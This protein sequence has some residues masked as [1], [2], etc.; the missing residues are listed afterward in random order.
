MERIRPLRAVLPLLALGSLLLAGAAAGQPSRLGPL[1]GPAPG[2]P[3]AIAME[4]LRG[5]RAALGLFPGDLEEVLVRDRYVTGR[6]GVTHLYLRQ[7]LGGIDV[8][9]A[10]TSVGVDRSGRIVALGL[11]F[12]PDLRR[13]V[14]PRR[15]VLSAAEAVEAA[16]AS[17]GLAATALLELREREVGP[18]RAQLFEPGGLSRDPIPVRLEYVA[19]GSSLRL[20]WNV[21]IRTP[22]GRHWWNLHVDAESGELLRGDDWID[23]DSYQVFPLPLASPDEGPRSLVVDAADPLASPFGWH[24]TNGAPGAEFSD[25]RGNNVSAQEDAD[26]NDTGGYRPDGGPAR[27]FDFPL[28]QGLQPSNNRDAA[29]AQLFHLTSVIHDVMYHYGFDEAA[30]NFQLNNYGRGGLAGDPVQADAQDGADLDNARF[31]TPPDGGDGRMEMFLWEQDPA[32]HVEV[33]S[34]P[35]VAGSYPAGKALFGAGTSGLGGA[36]VRALDPANASGPSTSDACSPL[37]NPGAVAGNIALIDR[38]TCL[39]VEKVAR[40]QDAGAS[41]VIVVNNQGNA[42]V[43][44]A[45]V[46][47]SLLIPALFLGQATGNAIAAALGSGV[48]ATLVSPADRDSAFDSGVVVHEYGHGV[49]NRL[50]G[51]PG[52]VSCLDAPQSLGMGEGW[53]D[54]FALVFTAQPGDAPED[55]RSIAP[56]LL[57]EPPSGPGIRNF[58]YST[59]LTVSPLTYGD[60]SGLNQ[61]HGVGEVWAAALWELYWNLVFVYGFEPDLIGGSGGN[62]RALALVMDGLK[63]QPC[64]PTFV[65]GRDAIVNADLVSAAGAHRCLVFAAFAKRGVGWS[66]FDGGGPNN[67]T[68]TEAFDLPAGCDPLC[69]DGT[70]QVGEQCDDGNSEPGDGCEDDCSIP[71]PEPDAALL[72]L[73]GLALLRL[74]GRQR[75]R[76]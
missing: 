71:L 35:S 7:Q 48:S 2:D 43:D 8:F 62:N 26:Q 23:H 32:H 57:G 75:I 30:G 56:Y 28:E 4:H 50:T 51:G 61:P 66:A 63:L 73:S 72:L 10:D 16:A 52:N 31:A 24:D 20:A 3:L 40:A 67:L 49:S 17:L 41:G 74:L 22:D 58:P 29:I 76:P 59:D 64:D 12:A 60:V 15:A 42:L 34:P 55:A 11:R 1:T 36:V 14:G 65:E 39:F 6:T 44:M 47:P 13:R 53:S 38:G 37:T 21:V 27:D 18:A 69:G 54:W 25:T 9:G 45:G 68:V 46:D 19:S 33:T 70:L 5:R